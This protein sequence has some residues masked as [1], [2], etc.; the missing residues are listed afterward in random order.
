MLVLLD[1]SFDKHHLPFTLPLSSSLYMIISQVMASPEL[2]WIS[3]LSAFWWFRRVVS[4]FALLYLSFPFRR[5][6]KYLASCFHILYSIYL[7]LLSY[8]AWQTLRGRCILGF[9]Y[10]IT[11]STI[12]SD[13][14]V[15]CFLLTH[16]YHLTSI[17]LS[18]DL[19]TCYYLA[20][21]FSYAMTCPDYYQS[22]AMT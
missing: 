8:Y 13:L 22:L 17:V 20:R 16:V 10:V 11:C 2:Q 12:I 15:T 18:S 9:W 4:L 19:L 14:S 6:D 1:L 5:N 7:L 3:D 21:P